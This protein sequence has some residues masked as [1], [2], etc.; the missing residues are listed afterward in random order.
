MSGHAINRASMRLRYAWRLTRDI[1]YYA[2]T[3]MVRWLVAFASILWGFELWI[4][5]T[6]M[7]RPIY[8]LM[9]PIAEIPIEW[10]HL[11]RVLTP[12]EA[13]GWAF[14]L[15]GVAAYWRLYEGRPR[16]YWGLVINLLGFGLWFASTLAMTLSLRIFAPSM[17]VE[18]VVSAQLLLVAIRTALNDEATSP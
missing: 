9:V 6:T 12:T 5:P 7:L 13:W 10:L 8:R 11:G 16:H 2:D 15:Y 1:L 4:E 14:I 3:S 18:W 17:A